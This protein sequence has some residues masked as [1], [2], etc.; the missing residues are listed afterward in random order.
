[1]T[2]LNALTLETLEFWELLADWQPYVSEVIL[3]TFACCMVNYF[4]FVLQSAL[5]AGWSS[6]LSASG[7]FSVGTIPR[8]GCFLEKH[9]PL[10]M[11]GMLGM[12]Y[13]D[14]SGI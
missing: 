8:G 4:E 9:P 2:S 1:M 6:I 11:L 12:F 3:S 14:V 7:M 10:G 5:W 13:L